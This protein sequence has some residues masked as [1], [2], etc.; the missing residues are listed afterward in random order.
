[1]NPEEVR[2]QLTTISASRVFINSPRLNSF[3]QY[4]V[5]RALD[6]A[7]D[8]V[9]EYS[10]GVDVFDRGDAFDPRADTIVRVQAGRLRKKLAEYYATEGEVDPVVIDVPKG[11]YVPMFRCRSEADDSAWDRRPPEHHMVGRE[12]EIAALETALQQV[13]AGRSLLVDITGEAGI[14]KTT[15]IDVFLHGIAATNG[16]CSIARGQCS[17]RLAGSEAYLPFFDALGS[18]LRQDREAA[19]VMREQAPWWYAQTAP[20]SPDGPS[21]KR[22]LDNVQQATQERIKRELGSFLQEFS[23]RRPVLLLIEDLHWADVAS[24]DMM[25]YLGS[26]FE[27]K[28]LLTVVTYRPSEMALGSHPF[29][30]IKPDLLSRGRCREIPLGF[31]TQADIERY[32]SQAYSG[33]EFPSAFAALIHKQTEGNPLFMVDLSRNLQDRR[34]IVEERGRWKLTQSVTEMRLELPDSVKGMIQRKIAQLS[35]EDHSLL[36]AGSTQGFIFDS[37]VVARVLALDE[38][39]LEE[40]L[41]VLGSDHRFVE[42]VEESAFPNR[43]LRLRYRFVHVLYQNELSASL[44]P[45]KRARLSR[46]T[47]EALEAFYGERTSEVASELACLFETA[48]DFGRAVGYYAM[49]AE[50]AMQVFAFQEAIVLA[51]SGLKLMEPLPATSERDQ[52][53]L[54]LQVT[55]GASLTATQGYGQE[56]VGSAYTRV[57]MLGRKLGAEPRAVRATIGLGSYYIVT[58]QLEKALEL[59]QEH[60]QLARY[61]EDLTLLSVAHS[62]LGMAEQFLG[63]F[64]SGSAHFE[65]V[66]RYAENQRQSSRTNSTS[67]TSTNQDVLEITLDHL[68]FNTWVLGY[69]DK[70]IGPSVRARNRAEELRNPFL[71]THYLG[72]AAFFYQSLGDVEKVL[73]LCDEHIAVSE[74]HGYAFNIAFASMHRGWALAQKGSPREGLA[75]ME[76]G[77][78]TWRMAGMVA[79]VP[80]WH[81]LIAEICCLLEEPEQGLTL[82]EESLAIVNATEHRFFESELHRMKGRLLLLQGEASSTVEACFRDAIEVARRQEAKSY[83]LRSATAMSQLWQQQGRPSEARQVLSEVY[84]RFAEGLDT[85]DVKDAKATLDSL[86]VQ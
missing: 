40:R 58:V 81:S 1:M 86:A 28:R 59:G 71:L 25:A 61:D 80:Y 56:G 39:A 47:A 4:I 66:L 67:Q 70:A 43:T 49:A 76:Q 68:A 45:T 44:T 8:D 41:R 54:S 75:M 12:R 27:R 11:G 38:E 23:R 48:R 24:I 9:K 29:L 42:H 31:L 57:R 3:L 22:I 79:M 74:E 6:G 73:E 33:N 85:R 14:G 2:H 55:L 65:R 7:A 60:L 26:L 17:E 78:A 83:E 32:L 35:D 36:A 46:A 52:H 10:I 84:G 21:D 82:L 30:Q 53:E 37:A 77:L 63:N 69:P 16:A 64:A 18:L 20:L 72:F 5:K 62:E 34:V 15:L 13:T 51:K 19:K 50:H